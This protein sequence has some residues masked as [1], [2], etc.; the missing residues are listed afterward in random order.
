MSV[1]VTGATGHVG[2]ALLPL[3]AADGPVIALVRARD[4]AHLVARRADL[5]A[6]MPEGFPAERL[7]L[8]RGDVTAPDLGLSDADRARLLADVTSIVHGAASVRFDLTAEAA[9]RENVDATV[10]I[11]ALARELAARGRLARV[12]HVSTAYVAGDRTGRV[13]E[14]ELDVG[15]GFRNTYEA[16]KCEAER[17][18]R[19]AMVEGLPVAVHRPSIVVGDSRTGMTRSFNVIYWPLRVWAGGWWSLF[20]GR[21]DA[22]V[23]IVPVDF[24]ASAIARLRRDPATLGGTFHLAA[25]DDA[26]TVEELEAELR[27]VVGGPKLRYVDQG[28]YVRWLRPLI[29]GPLQLTKRGRAIARGGR[30]FLPYFVANPRFDTTELRAA[31]GEGAPPVRAY[32]DNVLRYAVEQRFGG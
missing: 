6:M 5:L 23:D 7:S 22:L 19:A 17:R 28:T 20:P 4:D 10:S 24:V 9:T 2:T 16:S 11:L 8:V 32:L 21:R 15:Q 25:G 30:A 1:L 3:L 18:V 31:L 29:L 13:Y 27:R 12:D 26:A 14:R